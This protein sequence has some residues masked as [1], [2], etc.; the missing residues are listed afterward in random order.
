MPSPRSYLSR[1]GGQD[2]QLDAGDSG[3]A[4]GLRGRVGEVNDSA[5]DEGPAVVDANVYGAPVLKVV[6]PHA[7]SEG[8]RPMR[9]REVIHIIDFTARRRP[10]VVGMS[11]PGGQPFFTWL[12]PRARRGSGGRRRR[13][14][15]PSR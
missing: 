1:L 14:I 5:G 11:V 12:E 4:N 3:H 7:C 10:P 8:K 13:G 2:L 6:D 15:M 9:G